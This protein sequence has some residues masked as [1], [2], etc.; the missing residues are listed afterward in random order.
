MAAVRA[1]LTA[2]RYL[3]GEIDRL[4]EAA[5]AGF[6]RGRIRRP[7]ERSINV[8]SRATILVT[9]VIESEIWRAWPTWRSARSRNNNKAQATL[10]C[11]LAEHVPSVAVSTTSRHRQLRW[12]RSRFGD[13]KC[14]RSA[15][16]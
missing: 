8:R 15:K 13:G 5:S 12:C 14:C 1:L 7:V 3:E 9:I 6:T 10:A 16:R 2:N 4:A 11:P